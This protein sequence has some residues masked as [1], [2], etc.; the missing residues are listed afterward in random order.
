MKEVS[1]TGLTRKLLRS[2]KEIIK[3]KEEGDYIGMLKAMQPYWKQA[4][5]QMEDRLD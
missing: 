4:H 1:T 3:L 2:N 5:K